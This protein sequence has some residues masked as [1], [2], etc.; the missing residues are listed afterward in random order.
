[1]DMVLA[2]EGN[3]QCVI[4]NAISFLLALCS[5]GLG[6][7]GGGAEQ[8]RRPELERRGRS[9]RLGIAAR[10]ALKSLVGGL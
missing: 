2:K 10:G 4:L 7:V 1:M 9:R 5:E 6:R 3:P 8:A